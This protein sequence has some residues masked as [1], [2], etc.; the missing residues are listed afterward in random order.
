MRRHMQ[1]EESL[2]QLGHLI[3]ESLLR[4][5]VTVLGD[6]QRAIRVGSQTWQDISPI[7]AK[8]P[9]HIIRELGD[10]VLELRFRLHLGDVKQKPAF[11][12][13]WLDEMAPPLERVQ[14]LGS[15]WHGKLDVDGDTHLG[16]DEPHATAFQA[17]CNLCH[18]LL[19]QE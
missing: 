19:G 18:Q 4:L 16:L 1:A 11:G 15:E 2:H 7:P 12:A 10:D 17:L 3:G 14:V 13:V 5:W 6:K 8:A 9:S